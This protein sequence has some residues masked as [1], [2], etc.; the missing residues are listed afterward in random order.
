MKKIVALLLS[1]LIIM[2]VTFVDAAQI[3]YD[4][5]WHTYEGNIF[6]LKVDGK[7]INCEVPPIVFDDYSVVPARDVFEAMGATVDWN[8]LNQKVTVKYDD[9]KVE[10]FIN[11]RA[12]KVNSVEKTAPIPAKLIN[13]KTMIPVRFVSEALGFDVDFDSST[14]T[15]LIDTKKTTTQKPEVSNPAAPKPTYDISLTKYTYSKAD[16]VV[17]A[18]FTFTKAVKHSAF[19]LKEPTRLVVDTENT[20]FPTTLKSAETGYDDVMGIRLGQQE[21]GVRFV[22]DLAKETDYTTLVSGKKLIVKIGEGVKDEPITETP[23]DEEEIPPEEVPVIPDPPA[24]KPTRTV[25]L[26]PGHGGNDPGAI[27]TDEDGK[28]WKESDINLGVALK[29]RDILK[30]N[31][32]KVIMSRESDK[33]VELV[34]RPK[35]A[36]NK[37]ATLFVSVHTNSFVADTAYGIETWGSLELSATYAGITDKNLAQN[38]QNSVIKKTGG[39]NRGV[40]DS[41]TLAVLRHSIMP[42]VLIEVGFIS[43]TEEREK[44]F[45]DAYRQKLADGI[46]E[47]IL[48]T[49]TEMGL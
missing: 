19:M 13:G 40:K 15:I 35:D 5:K 8:A 3:Y 48:K 28:I 25:Y 29:V 17:T 47:G 41:T 22:F 6:T 2:S 7:T 26:D 36:N 27:F 49:L 46:A 24:Y 10:V 33:T 39:Y 4:D 43:N 21:K 38:I 44:M 14:D 32:V 45:N 34:D 9:V 16:D 20:K 37:Q 12:V 31:N 1:L 30:K 18:E 11:K 23:D 42:S